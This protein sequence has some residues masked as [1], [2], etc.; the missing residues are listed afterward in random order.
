[1]K[2]TTKISRIWIILFL[3]P[4][5]GPAQNWQNICSSGV[6]FYQNLSGSIQA[7]RLDSVD[8]T[9][10]PDSVFHSYRAIRDP[11]GDCYDTTYGSIF[12][13]EITKK[14]LGVFQFFNKTNSVIKLHTL[15]GIGFSWTFFSFTSG[16]YIEA[17]VSI[18]TKDTIL[19]IPDSL[20][21]IVFQAKDFLGNNITH[22]INQQHITLSKQ[23]GLTRIFDLYAFPNDT[24]SYLLLGKSTPSVGMQNLTWNE[25]WD[26][27]VG[28]VFHY[29]IDE[30][31]VGV[32]I[33]SQLIQEILSKE[34]IPDSNK[35]IYTIERC[36][37]KSVSAPPPN[38]FYSHD[39]I[40]VT[41]TFQSDTS[42]I[43]ALPREFVNIG[44]EAP[45]HSRLFPSYNERQ[46]HN[47]MMGVYYSSNPP[48][49][50]PPFEFISEERYTKGL[51]R[52]KDSW[53]AVWEHYSLNLVYYKK[54]SE[55]WGT[56]VA[57][58]CSTLV[59]VEEPPAPQTEF[60]IYPNPASTHIT[61]ETQV[62]SQLSILNLNGLELLK[63]PITEPKT[64]IDISSLPNGVYFVRVMGEKTVRV[65][66]FIKQ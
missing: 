1:M 9:Q 13:L 66:K 14:P 43:A 12:G 37:K 24:T 36:K 18:K 64:I 33:Y 30:E 3:F 55:T 19:G 27:D 5:I 16:D 31:V 25:V 34:V 26:F 49:W 59:P 60:S 8:I 51:G 10:Y 39:T 4:L 11:I 47:K 44:G 57:T 54:G 41:C 2:L 15:E 48:C 32:S 40:T 65:G 45:I 42:H 22:P 7:F 28:D 62:P 38:V 61:V 21:V 52:T 56:P 53:F 17:T 50:H 20:K 23:F 63:Q 58:D 35:V 46:T 29:V 6:T